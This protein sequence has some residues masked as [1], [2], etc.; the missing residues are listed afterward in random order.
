MAPV[1]TSDKS[2]VLSDKIT[3]GF[4]ECPQMLTTATI[5]V[6]MN[7]RERVIAAIKGEKV[8]GIPSCFSLHFPAEQ[9][10]GDPAIE[11]HLKF[12]EETDTD[13]IKIMNE[14]LLRQYDMVR[15][16][17]EYAAAVKRL[18][19]E[20]KAVEEQVDLTTKI[21]ARA[22]HTA[23]SMG[24]LH[25]IVASAIHVI[26]HMG[27]HYPWMAE[28]QM[29]TDF[30]RW[31]EPAMLDA[32]ERICEIQCRMA[33]AYIQDA[34]VDSVF[35]ASLGAETRWFTDEE[36][37]RLI[38]PFELRIL[39]AIKNAGGYVFLHACKDHLNMQRYDADYLPLVDVANWG[40]YEVPFSLEEGRKLFAG[41]TILGGLDDRAGAI[42][43]GASQVRAA[44]DSVVESFGRD[45][46]IIG[47]DCTLAT[48]QDTS[49]VRAAV[50]EARSL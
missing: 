25:G 35:C 18:C 8:D 1:L 6:S 27:E 46:L 17:A 45:G 10:T 49:I 41:K 14:H 3:R 38:K 21:L 15:T 48:D 39:E 43:E 37:E 22:E 13:I 32:F 30:C 24:T 34:G 4:A 20:T 9:A 50:E 29:L 23:F 31:D 40:V 12:F 7:K 2:H 44:V 5:G 19:K 11:A 16:P 26:G 36:W 33:A 47:A 28:R 42:T